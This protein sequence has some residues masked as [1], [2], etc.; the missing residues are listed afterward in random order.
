MQQNSTNHED[1]QPNNIIDNLEFQSVLD[2]QNLNDD[3]FEEEMPEQN[4]H[5]QERNKEQQSNSI[6][7]H[8]EIHRNGDQRQQPIL[9]GE[10]YKVSPH[11]LETNSTY[12]CTLSQRRFTYYNI[13]NRE[14][15]L[16]I[17]DFDYQ[18]Y[19]FYVKSK[20]D[21]YIQSF[22]YTFKYKRLQPEGCEKKFEFIVPTRTREQ[23][24]QWVSL[25]HY[26]LQQSNGYLNNIMSLS[27]YHR[28]WRH[29]RILDPQIL[30]QAQTGDLLIFRTRGKLQNLQRSITRSDYDHIVMFLKNP[31][32]DPMLFESSNQYGVISFSYK[33]F[34]KAKSFKNYE[35]IL[36]KPLLNVSENDRILMYAYAEAQFG[37]GYSLSMMKFFK[38]STRQN[39]FCSELIA[40]IY[41]L[42]GFIPESEKC[43]SFLPGNFT[44]EDK[45]MDLLKSAQLGPDY[46]VDFYYLQ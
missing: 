9:E 38:K 10:F 29:E 39:F 42:M 14:K 3:Q 1:G 31:L 46:I 36:Y 21:T 12:Y 4:N 27:K 16:G 44:D 19:I 34:V 26:Y 2:I 5:I 20:D 22:M 7:P 28:F 43:C 45:R 6:P 11:F 40:Y 15:P 30:A 37:K 24:K 23:S 13:K 18:K 25:I 8:Q 17:L 35:K 32:E 33:R 41:Q